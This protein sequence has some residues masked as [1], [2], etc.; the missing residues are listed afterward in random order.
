MCL[1]QHEPLVVQKTER[2][3][4][5]PCFAPATPKKKDCLQYLCIKTK[6][7][8]A[9]GFASSYLQENMNK[10]KSRM[11]IWFILPFKKK[12]KEGI[13]SSKSANPRS[14]VIAEKY[15]LHIFYANNLY[16]LLDNDIWVEKNRFPLGTLLCHVTFSSW[17]QQLICGGQIYLGY[18]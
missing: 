15:L 6:L 13:I 12:R 17:K 7:W 10:I 3:G 8:K 4:T 5:K 18:D 11:R 14:I 16:P 2:K 1:L 9:G